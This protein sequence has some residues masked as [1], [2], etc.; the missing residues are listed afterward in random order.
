VTNPFGTSLR[1]DPGDP[2]GLRERIDTVILE[3]L[4]EAVDAACL[5]LLVERR[6]ARK[7]PVPAADRAEDRAE[8]ENL[9]RA[10]VGRLDA[11]IAPSLGAEDRT[12]LTSKLPEPAD[13]LARLFAIQVALAKLVPDYWQRFESLKEEFSAEERGRAPGRLGLFRRLCG[14]G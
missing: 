4:E 8:F 6:R 7:L 3:R 11:S 9:V 1:R 14:P 5:D 2:R 13:A 10:F 12:R